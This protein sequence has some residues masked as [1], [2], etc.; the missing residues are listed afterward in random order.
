MATSRLLFVVNRARIDVYE[1]LKRSFV[2]EGSV[3]VVL[4]RRHGERRR[5][6]VP[7]DVERRQKERRIRTIGRTLESNSFAL[8]R[9]PTSPGLL[10]GAG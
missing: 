5:P 7:A 3:E 1:H 8:V 4:D 9:R 2:D 10:A 6:S